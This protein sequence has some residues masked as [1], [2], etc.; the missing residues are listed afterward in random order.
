MRLRRLV[1]AVAVG[2]LCLGVGTLDTGSAA[3][4]ESTPNVANVASSH[5]VFP[6]SDVFADVRLNVLPLLTCRANV[7][8]QP[9]TTAGVTAYE[10]R[11]V[12]T[13]TNAVS[14]GP[15][16]V[17]APGTSYND[18]AAPLLGAGLGVYEWQ[19]RAVTGAGLRSDWIAADAPGFLLCL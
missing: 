11:R 3:F 8:W 14:G 10:V 15:W 17:T 19:V 6:P 13:G 4:V 18:S 7:T 2:A 5:A 12:V 9:S 16:T 1:G